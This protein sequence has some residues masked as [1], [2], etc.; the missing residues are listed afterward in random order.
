MMNPESPMKNIQWK[1]CILNK[2]L[3]KTFLL[4]HFQE[5]EKY[6]FLLKHFWKITNLFT[7]F[8]RNNKRVL[9]IKSLNKWKSYIG[10]NVQCT[11]IF[12]YF[13]L[14]YEFIIQAF[15]PCWPITKCCLSS[16]SDSSSKTVKDHLFRFKLS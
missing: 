3:N 1:Q 14:F 13:Y 11:C 8:C 2:N 10:Y 16:L 9:K 4:F 15:I 12:L 6:F 7:M 5:R